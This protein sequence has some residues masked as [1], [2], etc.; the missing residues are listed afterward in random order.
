MIHRTQKSTILLI[1]ILLE[2]IHSRKA[3]WKRCIGQIKEGGR[4]RWGRGAKTKYI[5]LIIPQD[6][7]PEGEIG[8]FLFSSAGNDLSLG[9]L[10]EDREK[11]E[12]IW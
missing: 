10:V 12:S 1:T 3:E 6:V 11:F 9:I 4:R 8:G 7:S 5:F 2:R